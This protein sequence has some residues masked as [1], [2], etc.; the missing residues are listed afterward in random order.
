MSFLQI[1]YDNDGRAGSVGK[2][3]DRLSTITINAFESE[4]QLAF[5]YYIS[6]HARSSNNCTKKWYLTLNGL[7]VLERLRFSFLS[8]FNNGRMP[9][10]TPTTVQAC[11]Q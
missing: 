2:E 9:K 7:R 11:V 6:R 4:V 1:D 10:L 3:A 8:T 5:S